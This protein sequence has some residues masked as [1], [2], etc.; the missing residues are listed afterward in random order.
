LV[1]SAPDL[2]G[3][4]F[5]ELVG[6]LDEATGNAACERDVAIVFSAGFTVASTMGSAFV[7]PFF[8]LCMKLGFFQASTSCSTAVGGAAS[9]FTRGRGGP[10]LF[11]SSSSFNED[12]FTGGGF[13]DNG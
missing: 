12:S 2:C 1:I 9:P 10:P 5:F 4:L 13:G 7:L 11:E 8:A 6:L 3:E